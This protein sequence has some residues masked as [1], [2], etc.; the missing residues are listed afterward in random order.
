MRKTRTR[1]WIVLLLTLCFFAGITYHTVNLA[2]HSE[3]WSSKTTNAHLADSN[4]LAYAGKIADRSGVV[5]SESVNGVRVY[6]SD[7]TLRKAMLHAVGDDT[8]NISTAVQSA[9][10]SELSG[11]SF[12]YGLGL[13]STLQSGRNIQLTLDSNVCKAA[14]EALGS[15]KGTVFVYNYKTGEVLCMVS[16]PTYDPS[17]PPEDIET[18]KAYEGAYL[19]RALSASYTP[20]SVFKLVTAAAALENYSEAELAERYYDCTGQDVVGDDTVI[21][22]SVHGRVNFTEALSLSCN[23]YFAHLA[24]ELGEEKL[25]AQ[26]EKMGFNDY[27][28]IDKNTSAKS[29]FDVSGADENDLGWAGVGQYTTLTTPINMAVNAAA[30]ANGGVPIMPYTVKSV[31][32]TFGIAGEATQAVEGER[33]MSESTAN[34]LAQMMDYTV[35]NNYGKWSYPDV[36]VCAKTGTAEVGSGNAAHAWIVGFTTDEDCPL[37]FAVIVENGNSGYYTASP[38]ASAVL[39]AVRQYVYP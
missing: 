22:Y 20:G 19:N 2:V 9:Y 15:N 10:R 28:S 38:V 6:N 39:S 12:L 35:Q 32:L 14:Y 13:P 31:S 23:C 33:R 25:T 16:T 21:C 36:D 37:A 29:T 30:I 26:A 8:I 1:S 3:E 24:V 4:G 27:I 17:D 5:L 11:Y 7:E 18:N 34:A